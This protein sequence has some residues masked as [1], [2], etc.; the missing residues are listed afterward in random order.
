MPE[1]NRNNSTK[2]KIFGERL[3]KSRSDT[4]LSQSDFAKEIGFKR[5]ASI[6]N[7][8]NNK[9]SPDIDTLA[10]MAK[11]LNVDLHWL[12]TGES[13]GK[14]DRQR[15]RVQNLFGVVEFGVV[16]AS[17][18]HLGLESIAGKDDQLLFA[19]LMYTPEFLVGNLVDRIP[20]RLVRGAL[21]IRRAEISFV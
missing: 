5:S 8:E 21:G 4:G 12:I 16:S 17:A 14:T 15:L 9:T 19:S 18:L 10:K 7:I 1:K 13:S 20:D 3:R 2:C 11:V 6:S